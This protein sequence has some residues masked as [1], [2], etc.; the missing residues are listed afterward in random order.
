MREMVFLNGFGDDNGVFSGILHSEREQTVARMGGMDYHPLR[1]ADACSSTLSFARIFRF[2]FSF[3]LFFFF[4]Q[5][6]LVFPFF[7]SFDLR[8]SAIE[9]EKRR[10]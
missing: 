5:G 9:Q 8:S 6:S 10:A 2:L 1:A 4:V 3:V 7:F